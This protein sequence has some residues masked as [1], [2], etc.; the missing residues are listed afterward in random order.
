[1][2]RL[3]FMLREVN[4]NTISLVEILSTFTDNVESNHDFEIFHTVAKI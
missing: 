1:M 3:I 2:K 4:K